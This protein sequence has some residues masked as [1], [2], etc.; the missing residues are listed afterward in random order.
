MSR[1]DAVG[2]KRTGDKIAGTT[3]G[4][5]LGAGLKEQAETYAM[6]Y[7]YLTRKLMD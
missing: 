6:R 2:G 1:L 3:A 5:A 7:T 4:H